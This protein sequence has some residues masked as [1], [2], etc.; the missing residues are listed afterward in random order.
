MAFLVFLND[1][2][3]LAPIISYLCFLAPS[4]SSPFG[5]VCC[6][7]KKSLI[8]RAIYTPLLPSK[9]IVQNMNPR[10]DKLPL[11]EYISLLYAL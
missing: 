1:K 3:C 2:L 9:S 11:T 5:D 7:F 4:T 6:V 8:P 10:G